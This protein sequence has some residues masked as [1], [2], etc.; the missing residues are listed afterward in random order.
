MDGFLVDPEKAEAAIARLDEAILDIK[1]SLSSFRARRVEAPARDAVSVNL[2]V[3]IREMDRR[4]EAFVRT[5][6]DQIQAHR[7]AIQAQIDA[8]RRVDDEIAERLT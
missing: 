1:Q 4:A 6:A 5:W 2:A 8:Y 3:Q 7:D